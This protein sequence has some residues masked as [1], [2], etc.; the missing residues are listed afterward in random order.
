MEP[1]FQEEI[2]RAGG[3][4]TIR[5]Q[6][7]DQSYQDLSESIR[8]LEQGEDVDHHVLNFE[9]PG[10]FRKLL[11]PKR[12]EMIE[13]LMKNDR[14]DSIRDLARRLDRGKGEVHDDL[15]VLEQYGIVYFKQDGQAKQP[16]IP[17]DEIDIDI[18]IKAVA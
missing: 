8:A 17:Y 16:F 18:K 12:L 9:S 6:P 2:E 13:W 15:D 7:F 10:M 1:D 3:T 11:T 14:P 4:L 5:S